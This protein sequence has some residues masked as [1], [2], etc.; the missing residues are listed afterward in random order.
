MIAPER[1][2]LYVSSA[3][4]RRTPGFKPGKWDSGVPGGHSGGELH[5]RYGRTHALVHM[6]SCGAA[7]IGSG[8]SGSTGM[9]RHERLQ[10]QRHR[11]RRRGSMDMHRN[12]AAVATG[13][14]LQRR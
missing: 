9:W 1:Q 11:R 14:G 4:V 8:V 3:A 2:E 12:Y 6:L 13:I 5:R 7:L 10:A